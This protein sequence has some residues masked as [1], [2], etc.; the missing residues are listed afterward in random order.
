VPPRDDR[1]YRKGTAPV[2][3]SGAEL[4]ALADAAE[5]LGRIA[6][7]LAERPD[8]AVQDDLVPLADLPFEVEARR[9]LVREGR[10][11]VV[12]VGRKLFTSRRAVAAL[13]DTL[14]PATLPG[15]KPG[16]APSDDLAV[17]VAKRAR[18]SSS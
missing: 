1:C 3:G 18:R 8:P 7:A 5:A 16:V 17:A 4:R 14:P 15:P 10:L 13:V 12:R 2:S 11:K 9:S 6:R